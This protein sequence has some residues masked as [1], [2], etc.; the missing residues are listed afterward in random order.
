MEK[1]PVKG[2]EEAE[3]REEGER[4]ENAADTYVLGASRGTSRS[5]ERDNASAQEMIKCWF[6]RI[7]EKS[8]EKKTPMWDVY[9][10]KNIWR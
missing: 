5:R 2:E 9:F 10:G 3:E 7:S 6:I 1:N 8:Y 4:G